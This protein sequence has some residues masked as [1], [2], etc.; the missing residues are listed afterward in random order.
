MWAHFHLPSHWQAGRK[1][2]VRVAWQIVSFNNLSGKIMPLLQQMTDAHQLDACGFLP[3]CRKLSFQA[4]S[5]INFISTTSSFIVQKGSHSF[6]AERSV[7]WTERVS[8]TMG[9]SRWVHV[10]CELLLLFKL[11]LIFL[12]TSEWVLLHAS[13]LPCSNL[14]GY[15]SQIKEEVF[16]RF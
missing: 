14:L 7:I 8:I 16:L 1:G 5:E 2:K 11:Q 12:H 15:I 9:L 10:L 13:V 6:F 4:A 3:N